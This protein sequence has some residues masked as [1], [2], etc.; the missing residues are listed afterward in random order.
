MRL[1]LIALLGLRSYAFDYNAVADSLPDAPS[2]SENFIHIQE[3]KFRF[4]QTTDC[5]S[6]LWK[7]SPFVSYEGCYFQ[8]PDAPY[9][10]MLFPP[11]EGETIDKYYGFPISESDPDLGNLTG[12]W[13][14]DEG[15]VIVLLGMTPPSCRYFSF[16]NYLYSRHLESD[17]VPDPS[18]GKYDLAC[19]NG[20]VAD[21][22]EMFASLDDSLNLDRGLNLDSAVFNTSFALILSPTYEG[23]D[24]AR[25][26]LME[27]GVDPSVISNYSFPGSEMRLGVNTTDDTFV[28]IMRTAFYDDPVQAAAY[29]NDVPYR[30]LRMELNRSD[31]GLFGRQPLVNRSTGRTDAT[32]AGITMDEMRE[33]VA[34]VGYIVALTIRDENRT[35]RT[36]DWYLQVTPTVSGVPDNGYECI[37]LGRM[38]LADCRDTVYPFST[39]IYARA[40]RCAEK[41][42]SC[43]GL[44]N[45]LLTEDDDDVIVVVGVDHA[46]S[47]VSGYASMAIY[48]AT[49]LWGVNAAGDTELEGTVWNYVVPGDAPSAAIQAAL[50]YLYAYEVRRNCSSTHRQNCMS[51]PA[52]TTSEHKAFIPLKDPVVITERMY[53]SPITHVG[54]DPSEVIMPIVIHMRRR[55]ETACHGR[56]N[57]FA[58][59]K[60]SVVALFGDIGR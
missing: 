58:R 5:L 54:P 11:H 18:L 16:S 43:Y 57:V 42:A 53:N 36:E 30:V 17:W 4:W 39:D 20:T 29:F 37:R 48:D 44:M 24:A 25:Q 22:C 10:L 14:L 52:T 60:E 15:D 19:P 40:E 8:N 27:S 55:I 56:C 32:K 46:L 28:T 34:Y 31:P 2:I 51:V 38:C 33:A 50:P 41:D 13:H 1:L 47:N 9:G 6:I 26:G 49:Y 7:D 23:V 21:R 35:G 59:V 3:G 12:T 45:G